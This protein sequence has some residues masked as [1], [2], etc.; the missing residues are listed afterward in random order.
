M[1]HGKT[2]NVPRKE[3]VEGDVVQTISWPFASWHLGERTLLVPFKMVGHPVPP[4]SFITVV[5]KVIQVICE[6]NSK[7]VHIGGELHL[8]GVQKTTAQEKSGAFS[9]EWNWLG[10]HPVWGPQAILFISNPVNNT[11][12]N[13]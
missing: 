4:F 13:S 10:H 6:S 9:E 8:L 5:F 7:M 11:T 1:Q 12:T 2:K 3:V